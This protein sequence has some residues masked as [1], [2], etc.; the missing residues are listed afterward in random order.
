MSEI[1]IFGLLAWLVGGIVLLSVMHHRI[2]AALWRE[3]VLKLPVLIFESDDWGPGDEI[4]AQ[5]LRQIMGVMTHYRDK[6]GR[7]PVV[8]LGIVLATA[9]TQKIRDAGMDAYYRI[10]LDDE[11]CRGVREAIDAGIMEGVYFPQLHGME[12]Y[13]PEAILKAAYMDPAVAGWLTGKTL[14]CTEALPPALQSRWIDGSILPSRPLAREAIKKAIAEEVAE[15]ERL[16]GRLPAVAVPPTFVWTK[17]VERAWAEQGVKVLITPGRRYEA[18]DRDGK[19][20][21]AETPIYAGEQGPGGIV[22]MV[23]DEYF[24]PALG[25][26]AGHVLQ[27]LSRKTRC[28]RATLL[29]MHRFNFSGTPE[30][31]RKSLE[32]LDKLIQTALSNYPD[33][34]FLSTE[35]LASAILTEAA[36]IERHTGRRLYVWTQ[37]IHATPQVWRCAKLTGIGL[38]ILL[39]A[40]IGS[41]IFFSARARGKNGHKKE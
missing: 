18:R 9:D 37:R 40:M 23:R 25:H 26:T 41:G 29:E 28:G 19:L 12:H 5:A 38:V 13:W 27:A 4:H 36:L 21:P 31:G 16:F 20:I 6:E 14:P 32:E 35:Q 7:H 17:D 30:T 8:T 39:A 1:V 22:Y 15:F 3:P 24:E 2:L 34:V 10:T 33:L 11:R